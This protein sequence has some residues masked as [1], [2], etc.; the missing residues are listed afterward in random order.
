MKL[1]GIIL[2]ALSIG[3]VGCESKSEPGVKSDLRTQW[4]TV[5]ADTRQ[6]TQAAAD[7]LRDQGLKNVRSDSTN[8]DGWAEG[9]T[10]DGTKVKAAIKKQDNNTS[11]VSV[12]VGAMG[13][14][15]LGTDIVG[16]I[17]DRFGGSQQMR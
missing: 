17:R 7:A 13:D 6:A 8:V 14:Q 15:K 2:V 11:Q 1:A 12:T 10:A 16:R 4:A 3:L 9:T 5:P